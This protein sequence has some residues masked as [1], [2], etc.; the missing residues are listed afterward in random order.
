MKSSRLLLRFPLGILAG[1]ALLIGCQ[2][3]SD[4]APEPT[5][6]MTVKGSVDFTDTLRL[7]DFGVWRTN[8]AARTGDT[9]RGAVTCVL[10]PTG[11][12]YDC[13]QSFALKNVLGTDRLLQDM[14]SLGVHFAT[15]AYS[16]TGNQPLLTYDA[17]ALQHYLFETS[18]IRLFNAD[19]KKNKPNQTPTPANLVAFY[20]KLLL[21]GNVAVKDSAFPRGMSLDSVKKILVQVAAQE[22]VTAKALVA[23]SL[24]GLTDEATIRTVT[25]GLIK[26][27]V[28]LDTAKLFP[29]APVRVTEPVKVLSDLIEGEGAVSPFPERSP[30]ESRAMIRKA[31]IKVVTATG[32]VDDSVRVS[33]EKLFDPTTGSWV[34]TNNVTLQRQDGGDHRYRHPDRDGPRRFGVGHQPHPVQGAARRHHG[35]PSFRSH[36]PGPET[37]TCPTPQTRSP[38]WRRHPTPRASP[39]SRSETAS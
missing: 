33:F 37:P 11:K 36:E 32:V 24:L 34:L 20:A 17:S 4:P 26:A 29:P 35:I 21:D 39:K 25:D 10:K 18:L 5:T 9:G 1:M 28:P 30:V 22:G 15:L 7:P 6:G 14:Y 3:G 19:F 27:G 31:E 8:N 2:L 13:S 38:L 16:Q 12:S 23:K